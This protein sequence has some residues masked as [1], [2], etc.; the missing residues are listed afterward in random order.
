MDIKITRGNGL[1]LEVEKFFSSSSAVTKE[2]PGKTKGL[3]IL[4]VVK[5][6]T[7]TV[8]SEITINLP[9]DIVKDRVVRIEHNKGKIRAAVTGQKIGICLQR[10]TEAKLTE[11]LNQPSS[12]S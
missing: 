6:G 12:R 10:S 7:L 2:A 4:C 8:G 3:I 1:E 5:N 9:E 11:L